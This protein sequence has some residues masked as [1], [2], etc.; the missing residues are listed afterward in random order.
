MILVKAPDGREFAVDEK[1]VTL[2]AYRT[3]F[4]DHKQ[5]GGPDDPVVLIKYD[6]A[7]SF[8]KTKGNRLLRADEWQL[9]STTAGFVVSPAGIME[10]VEP[11]DDKK[12]VMQHGKSEVRP[13]KEFKDVTFRMAHDI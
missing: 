1:P 2:T 9:A 5:S 3:V 4:A 12:N 11:R 7:R 8:A 13:N 10:W 6:E